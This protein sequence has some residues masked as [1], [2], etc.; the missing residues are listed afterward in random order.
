MSS[1]RNNQKR[2]QAEAPPV[3]NPPTPKEEEQQTQ[4]L[5]F[6]VPTEFVDLP[7][8]GLYY[9]NGHPLHSV[10]TVEIR[11]MTA[12]EEDILAS[13]SLIRKGIVLDRMLQSIL[14]VL[15]SKS[16][17]AQMKKQLRSY[18]IEFQRPAPRA[19]CFH[20]LRRCGAEFV[21]KGVAFC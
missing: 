3:D 20:D 11:H 4:G 1:T 14:V 16:T 10:D 5:S 18:A 13:Q 8:K 9:P 21:R 6:S 12:K 19:V 2:L 7:S 17:E 15:Q